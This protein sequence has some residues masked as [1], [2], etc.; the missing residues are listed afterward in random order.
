M[1]HLNIGSNLDSKFGNRFINIS[2]AI[3]LLINSELKIIKISNFFKT[4][5]YPN[6]KH[7]YFLNVG[8]FANYESDEITLLKLVKTID[9]SPASSIAL[10]VASNSAIFPSALIF[11]LMP[12]A[13]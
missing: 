11:R 5:S 13:A 1:I 7:P 8:V 12:L 4:P 10:S 9:R 6:K 2:N 3:N